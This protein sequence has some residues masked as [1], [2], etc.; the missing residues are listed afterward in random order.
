MARAYW[1]SAVGSRPAR[2]KA[3]P[4]LYAIGLQSLGLTVSQELSPRFNANDLGYQVIAY[5]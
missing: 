5:L 2:L 3:V 4:K 1:A